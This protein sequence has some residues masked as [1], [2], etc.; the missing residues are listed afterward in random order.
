MKVNSRGDTMISVL[1]GIVLLS[2]VI[3]ASVQ[4]SAGMQLI[5]ANMRQLLQGGMVSL[6]V[7]ELLKARTQTI[8]ASAESSSVKLAQVNSFVSALRTRLPLL[9]NDRS[10]VGGYN[11]HVSQA[12][13]VQGDLAEITLDVN[14]NSTTGQRDAIDRQVLKL[15]L[16]AVNN[17]GNNAGSNVTILG[18][19][20]LTDI[21]SGTAH[22]PDYSQVPDDAPPTQPVQPESPTEVA[23]MPTPSNSLQQILQYWVNYLNGLSSNGSP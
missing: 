8:A 11:I 7:T 13:L 4:G 16:A 15:S 9:A 22:A 3:G 23:A 1:V 20:D 18:W 5:S 14:W 21:N 10:G 6:D 12:Q 19:S 2:V 17:G